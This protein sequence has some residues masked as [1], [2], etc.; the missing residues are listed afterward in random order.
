MCL[1]YE[2]FIPRLG[3]NLT[4]L[5]DAGF[6]GSVSSISDV[7][8]LFDIVVEPDFLAWENFSFFCCGGQ[9]SAEVNIEQT[10][11]RLQ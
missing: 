2:V 11:C 4:R 3:L 6:F 8:Q 7:K 1:L 10:V 9:I 5:Q